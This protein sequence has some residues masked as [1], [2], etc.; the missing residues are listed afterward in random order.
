MQATL[1][2]FIDLLINQIAISKQI[3]G[4]TTTAPGLLPYWDL[5]QPLQAKL[6]KLSVILSSAPI[7]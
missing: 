5:I 6:V 4:N 2:P 1:S 7:N 3:H